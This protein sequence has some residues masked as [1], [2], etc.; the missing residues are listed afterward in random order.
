[1]KKQ[2][3]VGFVNRL[4][5]VVLLLGL[6]AAGYTLRSS[7]ADA[8]DVFRGSG[9]TAMATVFNVNINGTIYPR[10]NVLL[11][12]D[13]GASDAL[14]I[15]QVFEIPTDLENST[16]H[17]LT[18]PISSSDFVLASDLTSGSLNTVVSTSGSAFNNVAVGPLVNYGINLNWSSDTIGNLVVTSV[19]NGSSVGDP[20]AAFRDTVHQNGPHAEGGVTGIMGPSTI[21][22]GFGTLDSNRTFEI[23]QPR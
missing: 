4:F 7:S 18:G 19:F 5:I 10:A 15:I 13:A 22:I 1:M 2:T 23:F 12:H 6:L 20:G 21:T 14:L 17:R 3:S 8:P 16:R 11:F 9:E